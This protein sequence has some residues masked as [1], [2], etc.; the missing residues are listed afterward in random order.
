MSCPT[1]RTPAVLGAFLLASA[2]LLA[3]CG[4]RES[5]SSSLLGA[6]TSAPTTNEDAMIA[7]LATRYD[8]EFPAFEAPPIDRGSKKTVPAAVLLWPKGDVRRE[9]LKTY[10][11]EVS[12]SYDGSATLEFHQ[13]RD[14]LYSA[15]FEPKSLT[16]V[17]YLPPEV[18]ER[19]DV[20]D[21]L[22]WGLY[23]EKGPKPLTAEV[24]A[25]RH[26][27]A[28]RKLDW[29]RTDDRLKDETPVA[30]RLLMAQT[31]ENYRL[32]SEAL[33]M[34]LQIAEEEPALTQSFRGL[35]TTLRRLDAGDSRLMSIASRFVGGRGG[36]TGR[37]SPLGQSGSPDLAG[38]PIPVLPPPAPPTPAQ[39]GPDTPRGAAPKDATPA[40]EPQP[41]T[42]PT[43]APSGSRLDQLLQQRD[44]LSRQL[45]DAS[46]RLTAAAQ[47]VATLQERAD[48]DRTAAQQAHDDA[49]QAHRALDDAQKLAQDDPSP[50][51]QAAADQA[52][53]A[54]QDADRHTEDAERQAMQSDQDA[55]R[56][57]NTLDKAEER[58]DEL[59]RQ[60]DATSQLLK[61][62][63]FNPDAPAPGVLP[64][65]KVKPDADPTPAEDPVQHQLEL[66]Q[67]F[68]TKQAAAVE[69]DRSVES[70]TQAL[71]DAQRAVAD[72]DEGANEELVSA[73]QALDAAQTAA[74]AAHQAAEVA[75]KEWR[76]AMPH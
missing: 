52:H 39:S 35:V 45:D 46:A 15:P 73:Q 11:I 27:R 4:A 44:E 61:D 20:G 67:A 56:A 31:L 55:Q 69:A 41:G 40:P 3:G 1:H 64:R 23:Y 36:R 10:A 8:V 26:P 60:L 29:I 66:Q 18:L 33:V 68:E 70:A 75:L 48:A 63:G 42:T 59:Q 16:T 24:K 13:G 71:L 43:P 38:N 54:C 25:I 76:N 62:M 53:R 30:R 57:Q 12:E 58:R 37:P 19:V 28:D 21:R 5:S 65:A 50:E 72:G 34:Y 47:D 49:D 2:G 14:V 9:G 22:T 32:Y 6:A 51:H 17:A 74:T 7:R